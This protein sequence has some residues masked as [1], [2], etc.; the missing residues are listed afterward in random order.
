MLTARNHDG[1]PVDFRLIGEHYWRKE[2]TERVPLGIS[3]PAHPREIIFELANQA[4]QQAFDGPFRFLDVARMVRSVFAE[5][6]EDLD[7]ALQHRLRRETPAS[8]RIEY[9]DLVLRPSV[10]TAAKARPQR[11]PAQP[12]S[13]KPALNHPWREGHE[14]RRKQ[15]LLDRTQMS[16]L[17]GA[18]ASA[19]P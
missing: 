14:E 17:V 8:L 3:L 2:I 15:L 19:S 9:E 5:L 1:V 12:R 11:E 6:R 10:V 16:A 13:S 7:T 18:S 4:R